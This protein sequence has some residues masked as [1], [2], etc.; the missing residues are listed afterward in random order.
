MNWTEFELNWAV[1]NWTE[2]NLNWTEK[3]TNEL[4][5]TWT[6]LDSS[7]VNWTELELNW[8]VPIW[9]ELNLNWTIAK[10]RPMALPSLCIETAFIF[11]NSRLVKCSIHIQNALVSLITSGRN[12]NRVRNQLGFQFN[13][14]LCR[15]NRE[16]HLQ[17]STRDL[18]N[19]QR[20]KETSRN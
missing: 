1:Q 13:R 16:P 2:L 7:K 12:L 14:P 18:P 8:A 6:E 17:T 5:W 20:R 19:C 10:C 11:N 9:S 3:F 4:N 15:R